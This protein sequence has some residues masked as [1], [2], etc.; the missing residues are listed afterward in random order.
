MRTI[1]LSAANAPNGSV[2]PARSS[3]Q[4]SRS[5]MALLF[6]RR[7]FRVEVGRELL[8]RDLGLDAVLRHVDFRDPEDGVED[9]LALAVVAPVRVRV[10]AGET[11]APAAVRPIE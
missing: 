3:A 11:E 10:A 7:R 2:N 4:P 5:F 9:D 1:F 8:G 6:L